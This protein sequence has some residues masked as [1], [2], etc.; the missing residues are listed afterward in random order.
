MSSTTPMTAASAAAPTGSSG[1]TPTPA[2]TSTCMNQA[3]AT[4]FGMPSGIKLSQFDG[5]DWSNWS[6]MLEALLTLHEAED[7]FL[8][9]LA[10]SGVDVDEWSSIQRRTKVYLRLYVKPN[11]FS[12]IASNSELPT[13]KE[14]WDKLTQVYGGATSSTTIFN[15]WIQLTQVHLDDSQPMTSQLAKLNESRVALA[16]ASMGVTDTQYCLILLNALPSSYE[17]LA[18]TILAAGPPSALKH[19][20]ISAHIINEEG[21]HSSGSSSLNAARAAPIK[22]TKGKA[23]DHSNLTC[24]YSKKKG[25]IQHDCHKKKKDEKDKEKKDKGSVSG[26]STK[27]VNSHVV[28]TTASIQEV[29]DDMSVA[30]YA[31]SRSCWM[32][33]SGATHHISPHRSDFKDFTPS[34]GTVRIG[35]S[36]TISQEGVGTVVFKSPQGYS[37][38]LSNVLYVPAVKTCFMST[39]ALAQKGAEITFLKGHFKSL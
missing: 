18:S 32:M 19:T 2:A 22:G 5:S 27:A 15:L 28:E 1:S 30:L 33:D 8:M 10:P 29:N 3:Y 14:K 23:R 39:R 25:H 13:F 26:S 20:E 31:T 37:L 7:V 4:T 38:T 36:S 34:K 12:L 17:V 16:N 6:G 9:T 21:R 11:V 24:H 35:D